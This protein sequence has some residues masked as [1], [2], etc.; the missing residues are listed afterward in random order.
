[1][2]DALT[3]R[4]KPPATAIVA[5]ERSEQS[6]WLERQPAFVRNWL[7][8]TGFRAEHGKLSLVPGR[9]GKLAQVVLGLGDG[10]DPWDFAAPVG[11]LPPGRYRLD[12][13]LSPE[14]ASFAAMAWALASYGFSRYKSRDR[15]AAVLLWPKGADREQVERTVA[16]IAEGRDLVNTPAS[17]MGPIEL[18]AAA[19]AVAKRFDARCEVIVGDG[20]LARNYPTIHAVGRASTR[21]PRLVDIRWGDANAPRLTLVG[22]GVCF[23]SG[24]LDLK[25]ASGMKLMKKDMGG[26]ASVLALAHMIMDA[27]LPVQL[28]VL[29]PIVENS[30]AGNAYRPGDVIRTRKG[31]TVEIGNTDAEGRLILCDALAE[32]DTEDPD[33]LIDFATLTGAARVALGTDLPALFCSDD[34]VR[35]AIL[36]AGVAQHDPLWALPLFAPYR[37]HLDSPIADLNNVGSVSEGGAITA[38]L[39]LREFVAK[40]RR[41]VHIDTMAWNVSARPGRPAGGEILGVRG[42]FAALAQ[43]YRVP[44]TSTPASAPSRRR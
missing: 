30:V 2:L 11:K 27:R 4:A 40:H 28:R 43:R 22:K 39:F 33:L 42:V 5:L 3:T 29:L 31:T 12:R 9:D 21:A 35:D 44:A 34:G 37:K 20:L 26:A 1:M 32:A 16:A 23:D 41:F 14:R 17:D 25:T 24:G 38:A 18:A 6:K 8:S 10:T 15:K 36:A 13:P 19:I 7:A